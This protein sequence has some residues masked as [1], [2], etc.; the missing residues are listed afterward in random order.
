MQS[1]I[2]DSAQSPTAASVRCPVCFE[3]TACMLELYCSHRLCVG[4]AARCDGTGHT[5]CPVCRHPHLLDPQRLR[6]RNADWRSAYADWRRGRTKGSK[7]EGAA[8]VRP[9]PKVVGGVSTSLRAGDLIL[10]QAST[11]PNPIAALQPSAVRTSA[12]RTVGGGALIVGLWGAAAVCLVEAQRGSAL[13]IGTVVCWSGVGWVLGGTAASAFGPRRPAKR[14]GLCVAMPLLSVLATMAYGA[15]LTSALSVSLCQFTVL[16]G[17]T[18]WPILI[19]AARARALPSVG[20]CLGVVGMIVGC[21]LLGT[22]VPATAATNASTP[23]TIGGIGL[24]VAVAAWT[25]NQTMWSLQLAPTDGAAWVL[26]GALATVV[27]LALGPESDRRAPLLL[28]LSTLGALVGVLVFERTAGR[29]PAAALGACVQ[30][31]NVVPVVWDLYGR[32]VPPT[33]ILGILVTLGAATLL[34]LDQPS[35]G[36]WRTGSASR[37]PTGGSMERRGGW[38][39]NCGLGSFPSIKEDGAREAPS[40]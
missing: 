19:T 39:G 26:G 21:V 22:A 12:V 15:A 33:A 25:A 10:I 32:T 14:S 1:G 31:Y 36:L 6:A 23:T 30:A 2:D 5:R 29:R 28:L 40:K 11:V 24:A 17:L 35:T 34:A 16:G 37:N 27:G 18:L 20:R 13:S 3:P 9:E 8:I 7:G 4:C 38:L